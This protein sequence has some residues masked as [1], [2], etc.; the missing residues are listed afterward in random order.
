MMCVFCL[1]TAKQHFPFLF[2]LLFAEE[3]QLSRFQIE[4]SR[5]KT[6]DVKTSPRLKAAMTNIIPTIN[7]KLIWSEA[8]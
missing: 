7:K 1:T 5:L 6:A 4:S 3:A 8:S 2:H